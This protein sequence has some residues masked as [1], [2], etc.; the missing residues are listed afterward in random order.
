M[1][2][3]HRSARRTPPSLS[4]ALL[5]ALL[6]F[7]CL[8][9]GASRADV[10]GQMVSRG[11]AAAALVLAA[12]LTQKPHLGALRPIFYFLLAASALTLVQLIPLPASLWQSLPA[13]A[14][15]AGAVTGAQ[16]WRPLA[17]QPS[18]TLNAAMSLL[19]P[20]S[21]LLLAAGMN[22]S[23][24]ERVLPILLCVIFASALIGLVQ[25]SGNAFDN[26]LVNEIPGSISGLL[27]N[28]NHFAL[29]LAFGCLIAPV[30]ASLDARRALWRILLAFG[31]IV[32]FLLLILASGSRAGILSGAIAT[33]AGLMLARRT[34]VSTFA[35]MPRWAQISGALVIIGAV[36]A[37]ILISIAS[38]RAQSVD[39]IMALD[40][41]EDMRS[42]GLSTNLAMLRAAFPFGVGSGGFDAF[43]RI[44][45]PDGLL[46]FTY[47]NHAHNDFLEIVIEGGLAGAALLLTAL[48]WWIYGSVRIWRR[49]PS[50]EVQLGRMGSVILLL[51]FI[52]SVFD[53]PART[54]LMMVVA[55][56]AAAWMSW[57]L[58]AS[59]QAALPTDKLHL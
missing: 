59:A 36:A 46:K 16:P 18:A 42:R 52:A 40:A 55:I 9:G 41:T 35:W 43:F 2:P 48:G 39:R 50:I 51:F 44:N 33:I 5:L 21:A 15:F 8:A 7:L 19:V 47:F 26:P 30:W 38:D 28:R 1:P 4:F 27:A 14:P 34:L 37:V 25:I 54:P 32:L 12:L 17:I 56:L 58:K 22:R 11:A 10:Y 31:L 53:Y 57:G 20:M 49:T 13:R 29:L 6:A 23:D 3:S 45:E 24:R